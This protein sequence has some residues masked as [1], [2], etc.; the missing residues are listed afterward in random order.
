MPNWIEKTE[1]DVGVKGLPQIITGLSLI[2]LTDIH[3]SEWMT[4]D[5]LEDIK[6][7]L[8]A[9]SFDVMLVTGDLTYHT[10]EIRDLIAFFKHFVDKVPVLM[11]MGNHD[12]WDGGEN[13]FKPLFDLGVRLLQ[14]D[15]Y[16]FSVGDE[17]FYIAG[18]GSVYESQ[19]DMHSL[20]SMLPEDGPAILMVHVP[21]V[22]PECAAT[23][24][25]FLQLSGH[26]HGGQ[27]CL[28]GGYSPVLP[29]LGQKYPRGF[30]Q[31]DDM[32]LYT[33]RGLGRSK[34]YIRINCPAEL[35]LYHLQPSDHPYF[36]L[37]KEE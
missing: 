37:H 8:D 34:P 29:W 7:T 3:I 11:V 6:A 21:D 12:I 26:S 25:F 23:E 24:R 32:M 10:S 14:N 22:A 18:L 2:H 35:A 19:D 9:L 27:V 30:Y 31:V 13:T 16:D 5:R 15:F 33:C 36:K 20:L 28:P 4:S 17:H 1:W